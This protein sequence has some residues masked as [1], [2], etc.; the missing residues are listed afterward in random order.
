MTD[1]QAS[2]ESVLTEPTAWV[3]SLGRGVRCWNLRN[4]KAQGFAVDFD[5]TTAPG[6][7]LTDED[8]SRPGEVR[9]IERA[10]LRLWGADNLVATADLL[11]TELVTNA[12][13]QG[14]GQV[15][16]RLWCTASRFWL[17]VGSGSR[18]EIG[19][20]GLEAPDEDLAQTGRG[21]LLVDAFADFWGLSDDRNSVWCSLR[22]PGGESPGEAVPA[23]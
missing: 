17:R 15:E 4:P 6:R 11:I 14:R 10:H 16:V 3:C 5:R 8:R 22:T 23:D 9:R 7:P 12:F 13:G 21:L 1:E 18:I 2:P 20:G 19:E